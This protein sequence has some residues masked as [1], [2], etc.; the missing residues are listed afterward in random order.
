MLHTLKMLVQAVHMY[1]CQ[2][3][4]GNCSQILEDMIFFTKE[5]IGSFL[6]SRIFLLVMGKWYLFFFWSD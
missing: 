5:F 6:S 3:F 1:V 4:C 2:P